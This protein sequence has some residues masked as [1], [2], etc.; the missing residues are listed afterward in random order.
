MK[1]TFIFT[2]AYKCGPILKKCLESFYTYQNETVHVFGTYKDFKDLKKFKNVEYIEMSH[3]KNLEKY[4]KEGHIG[5]GYLFAKVLN[6]EYGNYKKV[7]HFDSDVIFQNK[8]INDITDKFN[9]GY[10]LIGPRRPYKNTLKIPPHLNEAELRKL[11]DVVST[12]FFGVN[13]DKI[14]KYNFPILHGMVCGYYNPLGHAIIDFFDPISF[15][16]LKNGGKIFY[17]DFEDYGSCDKNGSHANQH[18]ELNNI[19]DY[20]KKIIHFAGIGSGMSFYNNGNGSVTETYTEWAKNRYAI[21]MKLYYNEDID[22]DY[23]KELYE[24]LEKKLFIK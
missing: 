14:S 12:Y 24:K 20:G 16:I 7:I 21:Y 8:C 19:L 22:F 1:D 3:D 2:E 5:T 9:E 15:D 11:E 17:L 10:D 4:Y 13:I 23:D 18:A 6:N